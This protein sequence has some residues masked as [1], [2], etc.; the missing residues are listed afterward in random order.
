MVAYGI[1]FLAKIENIPERTC[2]PPVE[3]RWSTLTKATVD[4]YRMVNSQ[5]GG[6]F[7]AVTSKS[8]GIGS[9]S[10]GASASKGRKLWI[11]FTLVSLLDEFEIGD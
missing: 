1:M 6:G 10:F 5:A 2:P 3:N 7:L 4:F 8:V 11:L 9:R